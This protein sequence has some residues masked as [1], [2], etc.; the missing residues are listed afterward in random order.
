MAATFV[1]TQRPEIDADVT[2]VRNNLLYAVYERKYKREFNVF[3]T[4]AD[5]RATEVEVLT[6]SGIPL[7][8]DVHPYDPVA[9]CIKVA[10]KKNATRRTYWRVVAEYDTSWIVN[11]VTD[12]PLNQLPEITFDG[13]GFDRALVRDYFGIDVVNSSK[14]PFDPPLVIDDN[15]G[16]LRIVR[17]EASFDEAYARTW[18]R[19]LNKTAFGGADPLKAR[20]NSITASNALSNGILYWQVTYEIEFRTHPDDSFLPFVQDKGF[21]KPDGTHFYDVAGKQYST[22]QFMNGRGAKLEDAVMELPASSAMT[23]SQT[24]VDVDAVQDN[25]LF[26]PS[27]KAPNGDGIVIG[28]N[29]DFQVLIDDEIVNVTG[30]ALATPN[31]TKNQ[32]TIERGYNNTTAAT[33]AGGATARLQPYYLRFIPH[34]YAEFATLGLPVV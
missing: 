12:N 29:Y 24:T 34:G 1:V 14:R 7:I 18:R 20:I 16:L 28:P 8:G 30:R 5:G 11:S 13:P 17:N 32:W 23:N 25:A 22:P 10:A 19:K 26:P 9:L 3:V 15:R 2:A 31:P 4:S 6:T 21:T 27:K 33:H